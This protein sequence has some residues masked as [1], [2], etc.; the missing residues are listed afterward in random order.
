MAKVRI[1]IGSI[2]IEY[3]GADSF[4]KEEVLSL[5]AE[6][7]KA[8]KQILP[9]E[10]T[11]TT[12]AKNLAAAN[13]QNLG[14]TGTLAA[15]LNVKS[16]PDL[17]VAACARLAFGAGKEFFS[18]KEITQEMQTATGYYKNT[19]LNNLTAYLQSLVK[20]QKLVESSTDTY[21]L[22]ATFRKEL[23]GKLAKP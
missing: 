17:I 3:E 11:D 7:L 10:P 18:R 22:H 2:E 16:G 5:F 9:E 6:V 20:E 15:K 8:H 21:A 13:K 19:Y 23:E 14:T 12:S 1:K 4:G